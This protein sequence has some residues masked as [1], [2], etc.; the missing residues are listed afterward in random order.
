MHQRVS[1]NYSKWFLSKVIRACKD[2]QMIANGDRIAVGLSGGKD[3][4]SLLFILSLLRQRLPINFSLV[5]VFLDLGYGMDMSPM[6]SYCRELGLK[7]HIERT[8]IGKIVFE[9][10]RETNPCSLCANLRRG[11]LNQ[12]AKDLG[13]NK[14]AVGHHL[15]DAAQTLIMNFLYN[16]RLATFPPRID[17]QRAQITLIRPL[18][19]V[20]GK[21]LAA[22]VRKENLP[23]VPN[24][25]PAQGNTKRQEAAQII[26]MLEANHPYLHHRFYTALRGTSGEGFWKDLI[27]KYQQG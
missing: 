20:E 5:P 7:L 2:F 16:G 1:K 14:V 18:V 27:A 22:L 6:E 25:C 24:L 8:L 12:A 15:D 26:S 9:V 13:C 21:V 19:Y 4:S 3:S 23:V 10:R 11:A 17:Y